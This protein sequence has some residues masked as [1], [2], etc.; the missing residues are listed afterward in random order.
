MKFTKIKK[1]SSTQLISFFFLALPFLGFAQSSENHRFSGLL[2]ANFGASYYW[3]NHSNA[4]VKPDISYSL[5][6]GVLYNFLDKHSV[7][8][9]IG[10][11]RDFQK[12]VS[13]SDLASL[14]YR[15]ELRFMTLSFSYGI[16]P[17]S[18]SEWRFYIGPAVRFI[19]SG[20]LR[21]HG[22]QQYG[23]DISKEELN[24]DY[25]RQAVPGIQLGAYYRLL[26]GKSLRIDVGPNVYFSLAS[27]DFATQPGTLNQIQVSSRFQLCH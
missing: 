23:N 27:T 16:K 26:N 24:V 5:K 7:N 8:L 10:F 17:W 9:C 1:R 14:S 21:K 22:Y 25:Y 19:T 18:E 3:G 6:L 4:T 13:T 2:D 20:R 12:I 11:D 15:R